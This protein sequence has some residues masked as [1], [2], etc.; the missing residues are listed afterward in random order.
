MSA[1]PIEDS[2]Q[3]GCA[4]VPCSAFVLENFPEPCIPRKRHRCRICAHWIEIA[5][6]CCRWRGFGDEGPFT[7]YAHPA[8]YD[9]TKAW[10]CTDWEC[11]GT[12][13]GKPI[14]PRMAWQN[15]KD[16]ARRALDSE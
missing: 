7:S 2:Q 5:E 6:P 8:C 15:D 13:D 1:A 4:S 16:L 14:E 11:A 10:D 3:A 12:E 9:S